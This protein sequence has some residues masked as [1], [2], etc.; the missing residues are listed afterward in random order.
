VSKEKVRSYDIPSAF[1]NTDVDKDMLMVL[2][3]E[4]AIMMEQISPEVYWKYVTVDRKGIPML[5]IKLQ[6]VLYGLMRA[7]LL[8]N[9]KLRKKLEEYGFKINQYDPCMANKDTQSGKQ[10]TVIWHVDDLM[11]S[12]KDNSE[13]TMLLYYL[14]K[15]YGPKVT[16]HTGDRHDYLGMDIHFSEEGVLNVSMVAYLRNVINSFL[17]V[18]MGSASTPAADHYFN[19]R[20]EG[21]ARLLEEERALAFHHTMVQLL[22][23]SM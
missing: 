7:S 3:G 11:A 6:K 8:L 23:M 5:C 17:E 22:F 9:R 14:A 15:I 20:E 16:M 10:L 18:I 2:K 21:E 13:L 4:L 19:M 12:W 1:V